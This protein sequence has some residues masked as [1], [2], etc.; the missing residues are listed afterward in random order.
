MKYLYTVIVFG[1][2]LHSSGMT[3][4]RCYV[5]TPI[6]AFNESKVVF[7]GKVISVT[8]PES[9]EGDI[10][11]RVVS[12]ERPITARFVVERVYLGNEVKELEVSSMTG[13][14]EWGQD[15][16]VGERYLVYAQSGAD[17]EAE[18]LIVK[19]CSRTRLIKD[20]DDDLRTLS[21]PAQRTEAG[22]VDFSST[23]WVR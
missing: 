11:F 23:P 13:G 5:P 9:G 21:E 2:S 18:E 16:K 4:A 8:D 12:L 14:L 15:F 22:K 20:A 17:A 19:G 6:E 3:D 1:L 7:I 10:H